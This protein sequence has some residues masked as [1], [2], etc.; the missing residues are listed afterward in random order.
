MGLAEKP[1]G[2]DG[3]SDYGVIRCAEIRKATP[4]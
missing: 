3:E 4:A 2:G 1:N